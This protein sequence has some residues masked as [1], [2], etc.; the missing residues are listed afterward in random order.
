VTPEPLQAVTQ[1]LHRRTIHV[2]PRFGRIDTPAGAYFAA[3]DGIISQTGRPVQPRF[4]WDVSEPDMAAHGALLTDAAYTDFVDFDPVVTRPLTDTTGAEPAFPFNVWTPART[5]AT[6]RLT[7]AEGTSERLVVAPAQFRRTHDSASGTRGLE[8]RFDTLTY[9]LYYSTSADWTPPTIWQVRLDKTALGGEF[10]V[11]ATDPS[12][13]QRVAITHTTGDGVWQTVELQLVGGY[14]W[15][16]LMP[17][18][19][20]DTL[21]FIAQVV[22]GAGNV[23]ISTDKGRLFSHRTGR[24]YLPLLGR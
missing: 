8:R 15:Q 3:D 21:D 1:D 11:E 23:A 16:A 20:P 6:N 19:A 4:V 18:F 22:D 5:H 2:M 17:F 10:W 13:V 7:T 24:V 12:G 9:D 14:T